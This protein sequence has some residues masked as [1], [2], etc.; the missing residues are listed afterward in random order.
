M[1]ILQRGTMNTFRSFHPY[2]QHITCIYYFDMKS[3][4]PSENE[5]KDKQNSKKRQINI[6]IGSDGETAHWADYS[7]MF[8][9]LSSVVRL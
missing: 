6:S 2:I 8:S 7:G 1:P 5:S 9:Q 3:S 4:L